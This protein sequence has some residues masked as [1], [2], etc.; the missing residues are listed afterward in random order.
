MW[1]I[2][3]FLENCGYS[4]ILV[5]SSFFKVFAKWNWNYSN[6][7]FSFILFKSHSFQE[8]TRFSMMKRLLVECKTELHTNH[9]TCHGNNIVFHVLC[10]SLPEY[11]EPLLK[12][13]DAI[14]LTVLFFL[15]LHHGYFKVK[16]TILLWAWNT[17]ACILVFSHPTPHLLV[18]RI[19][20]L[21]STMVW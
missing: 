6:E 8:N 12:D 17:H 3:L 10:V 1:E 5:C 9:P 13:R 19:I 4:L 16:M 2:Q 7:I 20:Y 11:S 18:S 14:Q 21:W 15:M